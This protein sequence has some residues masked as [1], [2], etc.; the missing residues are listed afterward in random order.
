[1]ALEIA[2]TLGNK[3][4]KLSVN[5]GVL[6]LKDTLADDIRNMY[7][8]GTCCDIFLT[9]ADEKFFAHRTVLV[10]KSDVFRE[11]LAS[12]AKRSSNE[13]NQECNEIRISE[14]SNPEAVRYMLDYLYD[15]DSTDSKD[16]DLGAQEINKDMLRLAHKYNLPG[17]AMQATHRLSKNIT[18]GNA[19]ERLAICSEFGLVTLKGK[20]LEQLCSNRIALAE[21]AN[22]PKIMQYPELMQS[23]L[24][25]TA[26][27]VDQDEDNLE[28]AKKMAKK[29]KGRGA[30]G[31][32]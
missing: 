30:K 28:P 20:I 13:D 8:T 7:Q 4:I 17:F 25:H 24:Q 2:P 5:L 11:I 15:V 16:S 32:C 12:D 23:L 10:A 22:S 26:S 29:G 3:P 6:R 19:V 21:V 27:K 31:G 1:M 14:A 9:C 18:T